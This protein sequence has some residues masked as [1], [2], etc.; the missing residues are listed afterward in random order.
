M[1][2]KPAVGEPPRRVTRDDIEEKLRELRGEVDQRVEG[3]KVSA[4]VVGVAVV[5]GAVV[6]AYWLGRRRTR[7]QRTVLEIRRI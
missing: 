6:V 5:V 4:A 3:V 1:S 7:R 2:R